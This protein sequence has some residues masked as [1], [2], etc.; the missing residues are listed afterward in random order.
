VAVT[1]WSIGSSVTVPG[2]VYAIALSGH[3]SFENI[4]TINVLFLE[5]RK[6]NWNAVG[7]FQPGG[8]IYFVEKRGQI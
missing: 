2:I 3:R 1:L 7:D 4:R 8:Q 5:F 6:C